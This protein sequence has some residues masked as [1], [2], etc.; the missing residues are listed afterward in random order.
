[1]EVWAC[2]VRENQHCWVR[3]FVKDNGPGIHYCWWEKIFQPGFSTEKSAGSGLGLHICRHTAEK[4][5]G[6]IAVLA[7]DLGAGTVFAL[8][9][10]MTVAPKEERR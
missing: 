1:M 2:E 3:I 6:R 4:L 10:P 8:T 9:L 5:G 7:S